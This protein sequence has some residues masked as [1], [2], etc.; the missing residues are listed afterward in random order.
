MNV[1]QYFYLWRLKTCIIILPSVV[2]L[3]VQMLTI[4]YLSYNSSFSLFFFS[5]FKCHS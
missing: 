2:Q 5:S 4:G 1:E 3:Y